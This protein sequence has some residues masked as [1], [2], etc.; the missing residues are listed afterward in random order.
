MLTYSRLG[1]CGQLGNQMF[2]Y[3]MLK[4]VAARTGFEPRIPKQFAGFGRNCGL[5]ELGPFRIDCA[6]LEA[7]D[8]A[9]LD[10]R[11]VVP[12]DAGFDPGVFEVPD[13]TDFEGSYESYRYFDHI[14]ADLRREFELREPLATEAREVAAEVRRRA[15]GRP[16]VSVHVRR[17]DFLN[18]PDRIRVPG[19]G[20]YDAAM[21]RFREL[22]PVWLVCSDDIAWCRD[23]FVGDGFLFL[24][25]PSH[26]V[27]MVVGSRCDHH[28][29]SA[30]TFSWWAAWLDPRPDTI[31][32]VPEPWA[33]TACASHVNRSEMHPPAWVRLQDP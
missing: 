17:G 30:S 5:V 12:Y 27:E 9:R 24:E 4:G 10:R 22:A 25:G 19:D 21:Q 15:A 2:Q 7:V 16:V 6:G 23:R 20:Y 18:W 11:Y 32:V 33:P 28:I 29:C 26:W 1:Y 14:A 13:G 8:L 31:V 3:A